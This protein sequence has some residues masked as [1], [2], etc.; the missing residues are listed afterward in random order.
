[1][2][3]NERALLAACIDTGTYAGWTR[4]HKHTDEPN[5][6]RI[7]EEIENAI[8]Y[9]IDQYFVFDS[10]RDLCDEHE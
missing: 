7:Q 6:P 2:R 5:E 10:E 9:E 3:A 1:M 8:W 4:A